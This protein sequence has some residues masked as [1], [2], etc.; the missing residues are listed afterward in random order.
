MFGN[1]KLWIKSLFTNKQLIE[2]GPEVLRLTF[3]ASRTNVVIES[4]GVHSSQV[5]NGKINKFDTP[6][7]IQPCGF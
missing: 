6:K 4:A 2:A 7:T 5:I 3:V 1:G